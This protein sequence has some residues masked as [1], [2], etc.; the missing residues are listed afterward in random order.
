MAYRLDF[1]TQLP[2]MQGQQPGLDMNA[3]ALAAQQMLSSGNMDA[4]TSNPTGAPAPVAAPAPMA[5]ALPTAPQG[6]NGTDRILKMLQ[7]V[8]T[9][10]PGLWPVAGAMGARNKN[11]AE[12]QNARALTGVHK[13]TADTAAR[14]QAYLQAQEGGPGPENPNYATIGESRGRLAGVAEDKVATQHSAI[15]QKLEASLTGSTAWNKA[16]KGEK[17][18]KTEADGLNFGLST[19]QALKTYPPMMPWQQSGQPSL[20]TLPQAIGAEA[21]PAPKGKGKAGA[22]SAGP[23]I[24]TPQQ[25]AND[26]VK[27]YYLYSDGKY[28]DAAGA[29]YGAK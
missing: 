28:R 15:L 13:Q 18:T 12:I 5:A 23:T 9:L 11:D 20:P 1:N 14:H 21:P 8:S 25:V 19:L 27:E 16:I 22:K 7:M 17:L 29:E 4:F 10:V 24:V 6:E 26:G 3:L 2:S